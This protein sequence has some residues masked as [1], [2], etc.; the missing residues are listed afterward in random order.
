MHEKLDMIE[1][2][3]EEPKTLSDEL[4]ITNR[5]SHNVSPECDPCDDEIPKIEHLKRHD[6][7]FHGKA[8]IK[9]IWKLKERQ[10]EQ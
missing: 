7:M 3:K 10:L 5:F 9:K 2:E 1:H 6:K 4:G 8:L